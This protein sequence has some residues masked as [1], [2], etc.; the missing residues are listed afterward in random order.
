MKKSISFALLAACAAIALSACEQL[1]GEDKQPLNEGFG[2]L[3]VNVGGDFAIIGTRAYTDA[4][5]GDKLAKNIQIFVFDGGGNLIDYSNNATNTVYKRSLKT[6]VKYTV[7]ALVNGP[8]ENAVSTLT[9]LRNETLTMENADLS[10]NSRQIFAMYGEQTIPEFSQ[11]GA[12]ISLEVKSLASRIRLVEIYNR[13][14]AKMGQ[15]TVNSVFLCNAKG[16]VHVDGSSAGTWYN[17]YGK[18]AVSSHQGAPYTY[19]EYQGLKISSGSGSGSTSTKCLYTFPNPCELPHETDLRNAEA[20]SDSNPQ[21]VWLT[22]Y[23]SVVIGGVTESYYWTVD[24]GADDGVS[25]TGLAANYTYDVTLSI[26]ALGTTDP[27]IPV[28]KAEA[29]I[30]VGVRNWDSGGNVSEEL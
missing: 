10:G 15:L 9:A 13:L 19:I 27:A 3:T 6:G 29:A 11:E 26:T 7:A 28:T 14:P 25:T 18:N 16:T 17:A 5:E 1:A 4:Y 12:N 8:D 21:A 20:I 30:T 23:G 22:V 24:V 2:T